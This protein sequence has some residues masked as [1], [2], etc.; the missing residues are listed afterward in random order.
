MIAFREITTFFSKTMITFREK[1]HFHPSIPTKT[2]KKSPQFPPSTPSAL[3]PKWCRRP[4]RHFDKLSAYISSFHHSSFRFA[5]SFEFRHS[6]FVSCLHPSV[7]C[8]LFLLSI[9][10]KTAYNGPCLWAVA[11]EFEVSKSPIPQ[12]PIEIFLPFPWRTYVVR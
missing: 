10:K 3:L 7:R 4:H 8:P 6:S 9:L 2:R 1:P 12:P 5:S 11:P